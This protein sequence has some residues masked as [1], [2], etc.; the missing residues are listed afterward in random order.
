[1]VHEQG[2]P[3]EAPC[4]SVPL[5]SMPVLSRSKRSTLAAELEEEVAAEVV[6]LA[7]RYVEVIPPVVMPGARPPPLSDAAS[8]EGRVVEYVF[9]I[10]ERG[11]RK[12]LFSYQGRTTS[13]LGR[14]PG[15]R[16]AHAYVEAL[17]PT[18]FDSHTQAFVE[19]PERERIVLLKAKYGKVKREDGWYI[20]DGELEQDRAGEEI[21]DLTRGQE[22]EQLHVD[23]E[24]LTKPPSNMF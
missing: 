3:A 2:K 9:D 23:V 22:L 24:V 11:C 19:Q 16:R 4:P 7:P 6:S 15:E 12:S 20:Y 18:T 8:F 1:M 21:I 5:R 10:S 17:W 13:Y 14:K